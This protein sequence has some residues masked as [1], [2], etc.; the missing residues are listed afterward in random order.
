MHTIPK[1]KE[2]SGN[3]KEDIVSGLEM[4]LAHN[5]NLTEYDKFLKRIK[6]NISCLDE[7]LVHKKVKK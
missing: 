6:N 2:T 4:L 3:I 1:K 7:I 5:P